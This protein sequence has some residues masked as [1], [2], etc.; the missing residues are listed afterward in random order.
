MA[1]VRTDKE[2]MR[3]ALDLAKEAFDAGE[4][5][6]GAVVIR[7]SEVIGRGFNQVEALKD[8]TAHA[9]ILAIRE[10]TEKLNNWRLADCTIYVI[11][12]PCPMCAGAIYQARLRRLVYGCPDEKAGY[13]GTLHNVLQDRRLNHQVEVE[14]GLLADEC[15]SLLQQFFQK[16]R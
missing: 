4:V 11:K 9:E 3:M 7:D 15:R 13:T 12:E 8:P 2:F 6:V 16:L 10:A 14:S 5:P 1:V